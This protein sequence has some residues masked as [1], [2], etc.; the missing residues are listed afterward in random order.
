MT[1]TEKTLDK[2][3]S[4]CLFGNSQIGFVSQG[5]VLQVS[6]MEL[7]TPIKPIPTC[8]TKQKFIFEK[9]GE[10]ERFRKELVKSH[11]QTYY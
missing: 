3:L 5:F 10:R 1:L 6:Y 11:I 7:G 4:E 2:S 8:F 9:E